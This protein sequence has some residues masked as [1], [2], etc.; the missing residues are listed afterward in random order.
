[1]STSEDAAAVATLNMLLAGYA[2][3]LQRLEKADDAR[4]R[5]A[6][7]RAA[8]EALNW[9]SSI[10]DR[11]RAHWAP[12]GQP[13]GWA[14]RARVP[15]AD[16]MSG[17]RFARNRIHHH[18]ADALYYNGRGGMKYPR[19][20]PD[21]YS[22]TWSWKPVADLPPGDDDRGLDVYQEHL[23]AEPALA[24]LL[25]LGIA[26]ESVLPLIEPPRPNCGRSR[27]GQGEQSGRATSRRRRSS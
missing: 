10:D 2:Y 24:T 8:F 25:R 21:F 9:A 7:F 11:I 18:W 22:S 14:W 3:A 16:V 17:F 26:F 5:N 12:E 6:S 15:G 20:Q 4:D 1:M 23:A 19:N 27:E 13:L